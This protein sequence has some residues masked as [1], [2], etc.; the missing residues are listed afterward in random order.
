MSLTSIKFVSYCNC[1]LIAY[2]P[3]GVWGP[4]ISWSFDCFFFCID[5]FDLFAE[6]ILEFKDTPS[7]KKSRM[8][9]SS[10][11]FF[12]HFLF[13]IISSSCA[14]TLFQQVYVHNFSSLFGNFMFS[15]TKLFLSKK[16]AQYSP[17]LFGEL[18]KQN[19]LFLFLLIWAFMS[20]PIIRM[21]CFGR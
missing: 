6:T 21:L 7:K 17:I 9:H 20:P 4:V 1:I 13:I 15:H 16:S 8:P 3:I 2:I 5:S 19:L 12:I 18:C 11:C 10:K 14:L